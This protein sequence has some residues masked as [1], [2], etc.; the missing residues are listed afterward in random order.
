M[1]SP[2]LDVRQAAIR[3]LES[4]VPLF[5]A[6]RR[7]YRQPSDP[8]GARR[9]L[10]DRF[11]HGQSVVF[12]AS[13]G[14]A[15]VGFTQLYPIFSSTTMRRSFLLND[16]YVAEPGRRLG[17]GRRLLEAAAAHGRAFG[18]QSLMLQTARDNQPAQAL[19]ESAGWKRDQTFLVYELD[20]DE[21]R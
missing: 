15:A 4:L 17:A 2:A 19:Y 3:D 20:L 12:L 8:E 7:F 13:H 18:A 16:L 21:P 6:Y 11:E 14:P 9:F 10:R 5:D 1:T